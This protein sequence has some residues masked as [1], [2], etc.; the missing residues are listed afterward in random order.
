MLNFVHFSSIPSTQTWLIQKLREEEI[1][2]PICVLS[3]HQSSGVG[4]RNNSWKSVKN[5]LTFSFAFKRSF[6]PLDMPMQ[7]IS[8]YIGYL[9]K[10]WLSQEDL[11]VWLKWPNDL[12]L[13]DKKVGGIMTQYLKDAVIC[14]IG[15]NLEDEAMASLN[16]SWREDEKKKKVFSFLEFFFKFPTWSEIFKNYKLEFQRNFNFAFHFENHKVYFRDVELCEDGSVLW[17]GEKIY[18]LR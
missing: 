16:L 10:E 17:R 15:I 9:F 3:E 6:L 18:S 5:A 13:E 8:I 14:G 11:D 1:V 2:L 12:Y 7:S 4:S